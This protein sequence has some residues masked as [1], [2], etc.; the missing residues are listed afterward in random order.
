[1]G[2]WE[3]WSGDMSARTMGVH[4]EK[5]LIASCEIV[6][7]TQSFP[8]STMKIGYTVVV[9]NVHTK[10]ESFFGVQISSKSGLLE[11]SHGM[12]AKEASSDV[13]GDD[14]INKKNQYCQ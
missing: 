8:E 5:K 11:R 14:L 7:F 12:L 2:L 4:T 10:C 6:D 3:S 13:A 9:G 1:M